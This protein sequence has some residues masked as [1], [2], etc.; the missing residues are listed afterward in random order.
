[1]KKLEK[2]QKAF[3]ILIK[4]RSFFNDNAVNNNLPLHNINNFKDFYSLNDIEFY[5]VFRAMGLINNFHSKKNIKNFQKNGKRK[6]LKEIFEHTKNPN[7]ATE[8]I[9]SLSFFWVK[10]MEDIVKISI[11]IMCKNGK[12]FPDICLT[13]DFLIIFAKIIKENNLEER[14]EINSKE[15]FG[16]VFG[17]LLSFLITE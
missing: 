14:F 7:T 10:K 15:G 17:I 9:V 13:L 8:I 2:N 3:D 5:Q 11:L 4:F 16:A 1:M 12:L 6:S